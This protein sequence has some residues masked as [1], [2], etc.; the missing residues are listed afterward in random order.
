MKHLDL[1][2]GIGGFALAAQWT[3][4]TTIG[5]SEIDP[6]CCELLKQ[7]WPEIKNY[8]DIK[9]ANFAD[10]GDVDLLTGGFPC[11]PFSVAGK[12]KGKDDHR[13]L[14]PEMLRVISEVKPTRI[15]GENVVGIVGMEL[16]NVL[17]D[18]E[19]IGYTTWPLI[20]PACAV[21]ARH[22][23][24]RVWLLAYS[25]SFGRNRR[26]KEFRG[27]EERSLHQSQRSSEVVSNASSKRLEGSVRASNK[28]ISER[29]AVSNGWK[30]EPPICRV[31]YGISNRAHRLKALGNSIVPQVAYQILK[32][33]PQ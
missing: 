26:S 23:R 15:L 16:D 4:F 18:L 9:T 30:P 27:N 33:I 17:A 2:S 14:W 7:H 8:G 28:R 3:G 10:V 13:H 11:Q 1:F 31:A 19:S 29:P 25:E 22:R 6:Y 5:F 12:K 21:D 20:I 32:A 24:D